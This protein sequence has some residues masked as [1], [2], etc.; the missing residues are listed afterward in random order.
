MGLPAYFSGHSPFSSEVMKGVFVP[1]FPLSFGIYNLYL[2]QIKSD[3]PRGLK[4]NVYFLLD[5]RRNIEQPPSKMM[6]YD[7]S[8]PWDKN[9]GSVSKTYFLISSPGVLGSQVSLFLFLTLFVVLSFSLFRFFFFQ[10]KMYCLTRS[11]CLGL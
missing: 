1:F 10:G 4:E 5:N 9:L 6:F 7:D 8:G 2:V 3:I 11:H